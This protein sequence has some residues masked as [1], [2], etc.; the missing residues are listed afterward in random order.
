[1]RLALLQLEWRLLR[2]ERLVPMLALLVLAL[3]AYAGVAGRRFIGGHAATIATLETEERGRLDSVADLVT[4]L[5]RGD[6]IAVS[7]FADPRSPA[8]AGRQLASRYAI[9]PPGPLGPLAVGQRDVQPFYTAVSTRT[10]QTFFVN[11]EIDN[12]VALMTGRLD[13]AF[14]LL[15]VYPLVILALTF[16][17][18][19]GE[20]ERGTL[21]LLL[22]QP[23]PV[24]RL[25]AVKLVTRTGLAIALT[26]GTML[27]VAVAAKVDLGE[28][29][30]R[31]R[32]L[33]WAA[34]LALYG[35]FWGAV[36]FAVNARRLSAAAS[37]VAVLAVWLVVVVI[38]PAISASAIAAFHPAPSRVVLTTK[39]R[40]ATDAA[41]RDRQDALAAFMAEHPAYAA[42]AGAGAPDPNVVAAALQDATER[43]MAPHYAE[44]DR[45]LDAQRRTADRLRLASP[46]LVTHAALLDLA[47]SGEARYRHFER[48]FDAFHSTWREFFN[49]RLLAGRSLTPEDYANLPRFAFEEEPIGSILRRLLPGLGVLVALTLLLIIDGRRRMGAA[50]Q[51]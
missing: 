25:L 31:A 37:A 51:A 47:G 49:S 21:G 19:A 4:R 33:V 9:L 45:R 7:P 41:T 27:L 23:M 24:R 2:R 20:R 22:A 26:L 29:D 13:L 48:Q 35:A 12:P 11:D 34:V 36:A 40:E 43:L 5:T 16:D 14:I 42:E 17:V 8:V 38:V 28:P 30:A 18:V 44:F 32:L 3:G 39:L 50:L 10:K 46:A 15:V 6:S 1:M